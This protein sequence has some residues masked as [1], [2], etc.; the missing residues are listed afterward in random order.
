MKLK[1]IK[2]KVTLNES[3]RSRKWY[4]GM[5]SEEGQ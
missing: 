4:L 3:M 1:F 2:T 5:N